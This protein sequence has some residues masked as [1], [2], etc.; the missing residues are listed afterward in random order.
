MKSRNPSRSIILCGIV[1][2]LIIFVYWILS[3][4]L[5]VTIVEAN[6]QYKRLLKD[7]F[8]T[9]DI[10]G[11][12]LPNFK[13]D[14]TG[15]TSRNTVNGLTIPAIF[16]DEPIVFNV[17]PND[18]KA[19]S[20]AL[21][22][23]IAHASGTSFPGTG[24]V[25]YYFAHSSHPDVVRQY[26]A[27]FYLLGKLKEGD[28]VY[29]WHDG[30][31]GDYKVFKKEITD[32]GDVSFLHTSYDTETVVLQTCWPPGSTMKRLLVFAKFIPLK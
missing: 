9:T 3:V 29:I 4:L 22:K 31:R 24:G 26:N 15:Y 11:V 16:V 13:I 23:G 27:V 12:F 32:P 17:D 20:E 1:F 8:Q 30:K 19:Y 21:K 6:Y 25:G 18:E 7:L 14:L 10:R 28:D 5:P 2:S